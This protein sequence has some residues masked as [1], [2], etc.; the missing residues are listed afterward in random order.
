MKRC[1]VGMD[2]AKSAA[3]AA[4]EYPDGAIAVTAID[5]GGVDSDDPRDLMGY[6]ADELD[7]LLDFYQPFAVAY[8]DPSF[9]RASGPAQLWIRRQEGALLVACARRELLCIGI[10][11]STVKAH[12]FRNGATKPP[13]S[14]PKGS[15]K[16]ALLEAAAARAWIP[17]SR[18]RFGDQA[19]ACWTAD[20][21]RNHAGPI[22]SRL[23]VP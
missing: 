10:H 1:V 14:A 20:A 23:V 22:A 7:R 9:Q 15:Q 13:K 21:L 2:L 17:D 16:K 5:L 3:L 19:D 12:A 11:S 8:E 4:A 18:R 6:F